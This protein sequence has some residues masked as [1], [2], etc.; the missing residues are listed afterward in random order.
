[1]RWEGQWNGTFPFIFMLNDPCI[2]LTNFYSAGLLYCQ[3]LLRNTG[4]CTKFRDPVII[5]VH[6]YFSQKLVTNV[7]CVCVCARVFVCF[8]VRAFCVCV[9]LRACVVCVFV[10]VCV[11]FYVCSYFVV[12]SYKAVY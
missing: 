2:F 1:M 10:C 7:V 8:R 12:L 9:R 5:N 4:Q 3:L 11:C 6:F